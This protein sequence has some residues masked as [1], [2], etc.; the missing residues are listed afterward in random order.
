MSAKE[1]LDICAGASYTVRVERDGTKKMFRG[2]GSAAARVGLTAVIR[3]RA[4]GAKLA[5][6]CLCH[7]AQRVPMTRPYRRIA[8]HHELWTLEDVIIADSHR[9]RLMG[10]NLEGVSAL[11]VWCAS[12]HTF[13]MRRPIRV[14][15]IDAAGR[16]TRVRVVP[17][18]RILFFRSTRWILETE[19]DVPAPPEGITLQVLLSPVNGRNT[20]AVRHPDRES[21]R[22]I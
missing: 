22:Y 6:F 21:P 7:S 13:S 16:V 9:S 17:V 15:E 18:R 19:T 8:L 4:A 11:V 5:S 12:I 20:H 2:A 1:P 14:S 3:L 10:L